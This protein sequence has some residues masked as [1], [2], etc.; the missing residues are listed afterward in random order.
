MRDFQRPGRS[1]VFAENGMV[2]TSHPLAAMVAVDILRRGGTAADAAV[3]AAALLGFCEPQM[4]GLGGDAFAIVKPPGEERL[5]GLNGSGRAPRA[6]SA[7]RLRAE[8]FDAVPT[9]HAHAVTTPG[10]VRAFERLLADWGRLGLDAV[11]APAIAYAEGGVPVA[12]RVA[13]DWADDAEGLSGDARRFFLMDGRPPRPGDVFRAPGQAEVLR[14]IAKEGAKG[15][16]EGPVAEDM[17]ESLTALGGLHTMED[18]AA[19]RADAVEPVAGRYRDVELVELPPNGQGVTALLLARLLE[20]FDLGRLDPFGAMRAH[21]EAEAVKLAYDARNRFVG[22]PAAMPAGLE[23]ML[24]DARVAGL[25]RLIDPQRALPDVRRA[26]GAVHRDTIY[27]CVVD[28]DRMAVSL[29]YSVFWGFGSGL[30]SRR[31]GINFQNRGAGFTLEKG[32]PNELGPDKRPLHTII[33]AMLRQGGRVTMPFGVM[34]GQYQAAGH[35]RLVSNIVDFGLDPQG[36]I[37]GPRSF[38]E[39]GALVLERGYDEAVIP[40]LEAKGHAV[41][42]AADPI[43]GAQAIVIDHARGVLIGASDP[44]KDGVA[45]G[46]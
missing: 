44:R 32:H 6:L 39:E 2:A 23:P 31:F 22:D 20:G 37:D 12:P 34:G 11:L 41:R 3:A 33:P 5:V 10:A 28:R 8:G 16:Y 1:A 14:R 17:V 26:A 38:V 9:R 15:F 21:L 19:V 35:V 45:L 25:A 24:A 42:R 43:G 29:I 7:E 30:A 13:H 40:V 4:T 18:F 46:Y 27:L 36:A